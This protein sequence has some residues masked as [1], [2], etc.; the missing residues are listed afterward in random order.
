MKVCR[1]GMEL[2]GGDLL[3]TLASRD[4]VALEAKY[5]SKCLAALYSQARS[6][7]SAIAES[8]DSHFQDIALAELVAFLEEFRMEQN[9]SPI[10]KL[11][12]LQDCTKANLKSLVFL[13]KVV[14]THRD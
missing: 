12:D 5:H 9:V 7:K 6:C 4:L 11:T 3:T 10:F 14:F 8:D 2:E 1:C 13:F